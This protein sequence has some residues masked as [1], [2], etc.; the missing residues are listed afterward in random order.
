MIF[1]MYVLRPNVQTVTRP[2]CH[3][4][5]APIA[6]TMADGRLLKFVKSHKRIRIESVPSLV[7][8]LPG[9]VSLHQLR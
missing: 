9:A 6:V 1:S 3:I 5:P 7:K 4:V 8:E 2:K